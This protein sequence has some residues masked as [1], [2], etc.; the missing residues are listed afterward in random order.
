VF[1]TIVWHYPDSVY[2][3]RR[4]KDYLCICDERVVSIFIDGEAVEKTVTKW[5]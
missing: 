1:E 3:S 2:E 5:S 4:I